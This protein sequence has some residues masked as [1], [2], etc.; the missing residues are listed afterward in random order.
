MCRVRAAGHY[1]LKLYVGL[2]ASHC[3]VLRG[4]ACLE[5]IFSKRVTLQWEGDCE[6]LS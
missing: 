2:G 6:L 1:R 5:D 4:D 3:V